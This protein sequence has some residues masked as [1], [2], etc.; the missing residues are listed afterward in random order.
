MNVRDVALFCA[1]YVLLCAVIGGAR[2]APVRIVIPGWRLPTEAT[3]RG[4][5]G[6]QFSSANVLKGKRKFFSPKHG[7]IMTSI[8]YNSEDEGDLENEMKYEQSQKQTKEDQEDE[9]RGKTNNEDIGIFGAF[10]AFFKGTLAMAGSAVNFIVIST[11]V[12]LVGLILCVVACDDPCGCEDY[13]LVRLMDR[14]SL[15]MVVEEDEGER[16]GLLQQYQLSSSDQ[17]KTSEPSYLN[18]PRDADGDY[19]AII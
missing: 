3:E 14:D 6:Y 11:G 13:L 8:V 10:L 2:A 18:I 19:S 12:F 9:E 7:R 16:I 17:Y 4:L 1:L 15:M 5:D